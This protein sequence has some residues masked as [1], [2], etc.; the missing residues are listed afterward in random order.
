MRVLIMTIDWFKT[1]EFQ[2]FVAKK[3]LPMVK[4][5]IQ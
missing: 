1:K 4:T 3:D 5:W 2:E